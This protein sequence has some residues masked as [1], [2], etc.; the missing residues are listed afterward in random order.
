MLM[1]DD[2]QTKEEYI[3]RLKKELAILEV[4]KI[5]HIQKSEECRKGCEFIEEINLRIKQLD[6]ILKKLEV[7]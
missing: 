3:K 4:A 7:N 1:F 5:L 2:P 6:E